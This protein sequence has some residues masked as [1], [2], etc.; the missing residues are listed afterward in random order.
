VKGRRMRSRISERITFIIFIVFI[1]I[2]GCVYGNMLPPTL[3]RAK[4]LVYIDAI[5]ILAP[6][7]LAIGEL[8]LTAQAVPLP[9]V[10][11]SRRINELTAVDS[12]LQLFSLR[13]GPRQALD[14]V[15]LGHL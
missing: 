14:K 4:G 9:E 2:L 12:A 13:L 7:Y 6:R 1:I 8:A 10:G 15:G 11:V 3:R 5:T